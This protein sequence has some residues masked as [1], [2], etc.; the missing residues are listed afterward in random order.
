VFASW[1]DDESRGGNQ[2]GIMSGTVTW[3]CT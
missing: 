3:R 2:T 1:Q